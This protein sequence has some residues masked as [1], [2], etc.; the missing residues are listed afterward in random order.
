MSNEINSETNQSNAT[1]S[2][3]IQLVKVVSTTLIV[4]MLFS[5]LSLFA[6]KNR[7]KAELNSV[8]IRFVNKDP[9]LMR[10][11]IT[12]CQYELTSETA[13]KQCVLDHQRNLTAPIKAELKTANRKIQIWVIFWASIMFIAIQKLTNRIQFS[14]IKDIFFAIF[15]RLV[16]Q[17]IKK[18]L[19]KFNQKGD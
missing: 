13:T 2:S 12:S 3:N 17:K 19:K 14:G 15:D 6:S 4:A 5:G 10:Q 8:E 9:N 16:V 7:I 18:V 11:A 1:P